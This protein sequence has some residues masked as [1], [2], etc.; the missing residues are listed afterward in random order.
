MKIKRLGHREVSGIGIGCM[1]VSW[2]WS[3][4]AAL[5]PVR[6]YDSAI[7]AIHAA[8]DAGIT[9]LDTA[10]I[11]APT[12]DAFGHN[13]I[14]VAE[15]L[16]TWSGTKE[17][18]EKVVIATKAGITRQPGEKWGRNAS[19]DYLLRAAEASAG[20]L[21]VTKIDL[22]QHHRLDP[23]LSFEQ[24]VENI[25]V[26]RERGIVD[27]IGVSNY[28]AKQLRIAIDML[29]G[30]NQGGIVSIQNEFSPRY[31]YDLDVL[32]LCEEYGIVFLP[33]SPLGGVRTK[34]EIANQSVFEE[35]A[36]SYKASP[37]ALALA[38]EMR[39]SDSVLP[40]PG[41][42]RV[43]S[44]MDC[45]SA[46]EIELTDQDFERINQNLPEQAEYSSELEPK[47]S[48]R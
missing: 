20:R 18:K 45:I 31:R 8:L 29:G 42:T 17:Q 2:I 47:P 27:Q 9:L 13:E 33:W 12:W 48:H 23:A 35:L 6:R 24:Q 4:G 25:G 3:N 37:F 40:I 28:D 43:E 44:I 1:N 11:Y 22:W 38:W 10:D 14:F 34:S 21:G 30:P 16:R 41:A 26:L 7:P 36:P 32:A 19:L 39:T 5:D 15:A 46:L